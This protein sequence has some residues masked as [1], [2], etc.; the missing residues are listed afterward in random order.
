[1]SENK[2]KSKMVHQGGMKSLGLGGSTP[3]AWYCGWDS[4]GTSDLTEKT[5]CFLPSFLPLST[6]ILGYTVNPE[7]TF[8]IPATTLQIQKEEEP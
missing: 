6:M 2:T 4:S 7:I 5:Y 3:S 8:S 1:M